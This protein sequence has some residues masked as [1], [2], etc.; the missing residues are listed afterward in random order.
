MIRSALFLGTW[1]VVAVS[2]QSADKPPVAP[3]AL[4]RKLH[5][6][7]IGGDCIGELT[8]RADGNFERRHFS[9]G[10]NRLAG[11]WEVQWNAF[12]PTLVLACKTSDDP[13][14]IGKVSKFKLVQLDDGALAYQPA[15]QYPNGPTVHYTRDEAPVELVRALHGTWKG[16]ACMGELTIGADGNFER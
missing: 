16:G 9:P 3:A 15:D 12:P 2:V 1:L 10:N 6:A 14:S 5:G 8:L 4:E 11:T 7:W 13:E